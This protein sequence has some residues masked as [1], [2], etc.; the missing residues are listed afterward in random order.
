MDGIVNIV[1][2]AIAFATAYLVVGIVKRHEK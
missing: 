1:C 2:W